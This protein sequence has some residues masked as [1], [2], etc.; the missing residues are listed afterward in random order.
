[1]NRI[2]IIGNDFLSLSFIPK[3]KC[4]SILSNS[5]DL[6]ALLFMKCYII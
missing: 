4:S 3:I 6:T 5:G 1:M 2:V